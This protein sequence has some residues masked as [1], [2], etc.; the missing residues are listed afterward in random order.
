VVGAAA[1]RRVELSRST[2]CGYLKTQLDRTLLITVAAG[3]ARDT[4]ALHSSS[5]PYRKLTKDIMT[6]NDVES[7]LRQGIADTIDLASALSNDIHSNIYPEYLKTVKIAEAFRSAISGPARVTLEAW[8]DG[9]L[10]RHLFFPRSPGWLSSISRAGKVDICV[11]TDDRA[12][13]QPILIVEN[14]R[15]VDRYGQIKADLERCAEFLRSTGDG[16]HGSIAV[17]AVTY[18]VRAGDERHVTLADH[19][20][21][22]RPLLTKI[23]KEAARLAYGQLT[24]VHHQWEFPRQVYDSREHADEL[25]DDDAPNW[26]LDPPLTIVGACELYWRDDRLRW[27]AQI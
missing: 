9:V 20:E 10:A 16:S 3:G 2:L 22:T 19:I 1:C 27:L 12:L 23:N 7:A 18:F 8:T 26:Y 21:S 14:K 5:G 11:E 13:A 17:T 24:H 15:Y 6:L 4:I 25:Q